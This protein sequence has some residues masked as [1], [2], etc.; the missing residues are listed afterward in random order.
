MGPDF[1]RRQWMTLIVLGMG[2]FFNSL[3]FSL[4]APFFPKEAELKG[5]T[6]SEYGFIFG[7]YELV[8]F[9]LS[10]VYGQYINQIGAKRLF[11][12]GIFTASITTMLFGTL[13]L[14]NGHV[15]FVTFAFLIRIVE[16]VGNSAFLTASFSITAKEFPSS[17]G[18]TFAMLETFYGL[19]WFLGPLIGGILYEVDGFYLPFLTTGILLMVTAIITNFVL[20]KSPPA[21]KSSDNKSKNWS[22]VYGYW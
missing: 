5:A 4:Q 6:P 8:C 7:V 1:T 10:P 21:S 18:T 15:M 20:P 14:I 13:T 11:N 12:A 22:K 3:C 16:A 2:N 17:V 9:L 19:G